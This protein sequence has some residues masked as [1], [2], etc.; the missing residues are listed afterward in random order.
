VS[1]VQY[2]P[3]RPAVVARNEKVPVVALDHACRGKESR[4]DASRGIGIRSVAKK[5]VWVAFGKTEAKP[6]TQSVCA[7]KSSF[8][9]GK[10]SLR[11]PCK[12]QCSGAQASRLPRCSL[13]LRSTRGPTSKAL[14]RAAAQAYHPPR[15]PGL[16]PLVS[17]LPQT[18]G[19]TLHGFAARHHSKHEF[20]CPSPCKL[21]KHSYSRK[22]PEGKT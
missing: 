8:V 14:A 20:E 22:Q 2:R 1:R 19:L 16:L 17:A 13:T 12:E 21:S 15:G 7:A 6:R 9:L 18:L 11:L 4:Q 5:E 10:S 3:L